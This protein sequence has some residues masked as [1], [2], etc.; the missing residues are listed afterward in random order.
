MFCRFMSKATSPIQSDSTTAP[1]GSEMECTQE[2]VTDT[3]DQSREQPVEELINAGSSVP[4]GRQ[5]GLEGA[6]PGTSLQ[7]SDL[8]SASSANTAVVPTGESTP[9]TTHRRDKVNPPGIFLPVPSALPN[10]FGLSPSTSVG[11]LSAAK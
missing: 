9:Y 3:L 2:P 5:M 10:S 4:S 7:G 8:P 11:P 6:I 1:I